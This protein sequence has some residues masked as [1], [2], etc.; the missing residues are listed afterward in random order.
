MPAV[1]TFATLPDPGQADTVDAL[2]ERLRLLKVWAGD[3]SY[4]MIKERVNA[5]WT[6][7]GRPASELSRRSTVA[8]C[9]QPGRRRLNADLVI[10][11]VRT[12]CPDPG[13][14]A[15]WRQALRVVGGETEAASQVRVQDRLPQDLAGFTGR[16]A[17]LDQLRQAL[18]HDDRA[19][20]AVVICALEGMAGVG[21]TQLAVHAGHL[22]HREQPFDVILFVNL[23]GFHTD[24]AQ[25]PADPAA[26]LEGFLRLLGV[27][28]QHIPHGLAAR[29]AAY[30]DRLAGMRALVVLDNAADI[31][32]VRP[33]LPATPGCLV[34][35]TSRRRLTDQCFAT[36]LIVDVFTSA[37][38][39]TFLSSAVPGTPAGSDPDAAHRIIRRCGRLPLAL[40]LVTGHIRGTPDWTL[41][42][43]ADR[44]DERHED[45]RLDDG[46][47]LAL[48]LSYQ[49]LPA[50]ARRLLRL[51]ALHPGQDI[52]T[53]AAAALAG[54]DLTAAETLMRHLCGDHLLQQADA[55]WFT[56][57]DL[58]RAYAAS[59]ASD[60][61]RP[62]ERRD[63]LTR[64]FDY[65]LATA[66]AAMDAVHP[67][68]AQ[69]RPRIPRPATPAPALDDPT[70]ARAWLDSERP[71]F[72]AVTAH[73]TAHGWPLHAT[74]LSSTLMRHLDGG[75]TTAALTI[76]GYASQAA[77]QLGDTA[78][79][80]HALRGLGH[81][82][83]QSGSYDAA[84]ESFAR[85][86]VLFQQ[87]GDA[88]GEA[89]VRN[90]LGFVERRLGRYGE[91]LAHAEHALALFR[92]VGDMLGEA[93]ALTSLALIE[94][95]LGR[96][97]SAQD[98]CREALALSQRTG[99]RST[100]AGAL[101][102]MG[103][104]EQMLCRYLPAAD[105]HQQAL[106]LFRQLGNSRGEAAALDNLGTVHTHLGQPHRAADHHRA[107]LVLFRKIGERDGQS[108]ALNGLGDAAN[109]AGEPAEAIGHHTEALLIAR[110]ISAPDQEAR[111]HAGLG[112]AHDRLDRASTAREHYER[113]LALYAGLGMPQAAR[114]RCRLTAGHPEHR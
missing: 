16:T 50:D 3:L 28:G 33:L 13:Y 17:E 23:R 47:E 100:E 39:V 48:T 83:L 40:S 78:A 30:R 93:R 31:A 94:G 76:H 60:E 103:L 56:F 5:A 72:V 107:A 67:A 68:E 75:H 36:H 102:N 89:R 25:P 66:A 86:L 19:S 27:P 37:E 45:R 59:R 113:A 85:A 105:H 58:I 38:A 53:Y 24:P 73:A 1:G 35:V 34:M 114:I 71:S 63:A 57:H 109:S 62:S 22:L 99:D 70:T 14:V 54:I 84:A 92:R 111:A 46:V 88:P 44:L 77:V 82:C 69:L 8:N 98:R 11:V 7:A 87:L 90:G 65:Y 108:W 61:D 12:L 91:A 112:Q 110:E 18:R 49:Y 2:V 95:R 4:E 15:Q 21:K 20:G 104:V 97:D 80:A 6:A 51:L 9:F 10:A 29:A 41:T 64:L 101:T 26:V 79:E 81:A 32:Q 55:N 74:R 96:Y 43:H 52:D 42:D 106:A